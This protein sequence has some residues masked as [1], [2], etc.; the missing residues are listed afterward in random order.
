MKRIL[1]PLLLIGAVWCFCAFA[2]DRVKTVCLSV[3]HLLWEAEAAEELGRDAEAEAMATRARDLWNAHRGLL[4]T[5]LRHTESDDIT[6][7]FPPL[8]E[9][10]RSGDREDFLQRSREL[11]AALQ[12]LWE[13]EEPYYY[14]V[15]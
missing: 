6:V 2:T 5:A 7:S 12:T 10:A 13:M 8:L 4:G 14:N 11:R 3:D 15:L 1:T 9:A